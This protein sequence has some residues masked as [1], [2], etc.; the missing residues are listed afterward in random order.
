[1]FGSSAMPPIHDRGLLVKP[2]WTF[3]FQP[4][5]VVWEIRSF[6]CRI[7]KPL[8]ECYLIESAQ[9]QNVHGLPLLKVMAKL[10]FKQNHKYPHYD[11]NAFYHMHK[12]PEKDYQKLRASQGKS[13]FW[14]AWEFDVLH[15]LDTPMY[16]PWGN[17]F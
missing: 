11:F 15:L 5:N 16:I 14:V 6:H 10:R 8:E 9:G 7:L 2:E 1:M 4:G 13:E 17:D 3:K 12:V